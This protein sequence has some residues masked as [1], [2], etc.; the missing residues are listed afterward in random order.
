MSTGESHL[1]NEAVEQRPERQ[2]S[3]FFY[4]KHS[5]YSNLIHAIKYKSRKELGVYLGNML[6][7]R[8]RDEISVDAVVPV[9]LHWAKEKKR[10]FNQSAQIARGIAS[11]LQVEVLENVLQ[12]IQNTPSQT[13]KNPEERLRNVENVFELKQVSEIRHKHLLLVDDVITTGATIHSCMKVLSQAE[14]IRVSLG[15]LARTTL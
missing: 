6:G 11:V 5:N 1:N 2:Y 4:D 3:L 12:R 9:P 14:G 13:G 8:I 7:D 10:G 15:C